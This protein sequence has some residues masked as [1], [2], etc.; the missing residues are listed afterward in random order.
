M[1]KQN[2]PLNEDRPMDNELSPRVSALEVG[3]RT[4]SNE[5]ESVKT[6]VDRLSSNVVAGFAEIRRDSATS[7]RTN[8]GWVIAGIA[9]IVSLMGAV[10][11][12]WVRPLELS[13]NGIERRLSVVES[14]Q[15]ET[16]E[17]STR[18]DERL[19]VYRET[20]ILPTSIRN[21]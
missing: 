11:T 18:T 3:V 19:R 15:N 21:P 10:G 7:S 13:A 6:S 12:A 1:R 17:L 9:V 14:R 5:L 4:L 8:W 2:G 16:N 20:G